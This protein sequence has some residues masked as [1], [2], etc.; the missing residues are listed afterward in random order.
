MLQAGFKGGLGH[1]SEMAGTLKFDTTSLRGVIGW[2]GGKL[3]AGGGLGRTSLES[4]GASVGK[5]VTLSGLRLL[6]DHSNM[7]GT[8]AIDSSG[9]VP[10]LTGAL[11]V[12]RLDL[13]P[14]LRRRQSGSRSTRPKTAGVGNQSIWLC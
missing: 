8:L 3:P 14:Y 2:L 7:T 13:N 1:D 4:H 5:V 9:K 11:A 12:D 6:L 10:S